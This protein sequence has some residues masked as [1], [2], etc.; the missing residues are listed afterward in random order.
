MKGVKYLDYLAFK[1]GITIKLNEGILKHKK[2]ELILKLKNSMNTKK[3][4]FEMPFA[5]K[6]T[7]TPY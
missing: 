7:I 2:H 4:D 1:K 6:I 3:V 5:H